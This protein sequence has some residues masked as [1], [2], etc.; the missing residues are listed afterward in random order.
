M[1]IRFIMQIFTNNCTSIY[2][3]TVLCHSEE[4]KWSS[5][6]RSWPTQHDSLKR[7]LK[8]IKWAARLCVFIVS[9]PPK[10]E[11]CAALTN[12]VVRS[13]LQAIPLWQQRIILCGYNAYYFLIFGIM[14]RIFAT[15]V[16]FI[17]W[18]HPQKIVGL[19]EDPMKMTAADPNGK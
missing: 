2:F 11:L 10:S 7:P 4:S 17:G 18:K 5:I 13:P 14:Y 19:S 15:A 6:I 8:G 12:T 3:I 16:H 1:C 9:Q